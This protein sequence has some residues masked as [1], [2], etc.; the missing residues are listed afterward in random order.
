MCVVECRFM[1]FVRALAM[2]VLMGASTIA[3]VGCGGGGANSAHVTPGPMPE[4]ESWTGV[5]YHPV[6]GYLHMVEQG[7]NVVG[8]WKRTDGSAWGELSG[9]VTGTVAHFQWKEHKIGLVG[10]ASESH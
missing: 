4:G 2:A 1:N 7:T 6:F 3:L 5:Y 8:R 9:T 10:P